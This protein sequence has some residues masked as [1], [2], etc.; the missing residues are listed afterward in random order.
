MYS[1]EWWYEQAI[2]HFVNILEESFAKSYFF[3]IHCPYL[4]ETSSHGDSEVI[5]LVNSPGGHC[6]LWLGKRSKRKR[7]IGRRNYLCLYDK[8]NI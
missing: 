3:V 7:K 2:L 4:T 6:I 5:S 8:N 1:D